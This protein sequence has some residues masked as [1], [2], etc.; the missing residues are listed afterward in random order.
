MPTDEKLLLFDN[1]EVIAEVRIS[2][3]ET[4]FIYAYFLISLGCRSAA[5]T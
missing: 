2:G 4:V 5:E 1:G 3:F